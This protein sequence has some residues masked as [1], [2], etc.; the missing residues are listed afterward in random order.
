[1]LK[2][3]RTS[4]VCGVFCAMCYCRSCSKECRAKALC[5][6]RLLRILEPQP[7]AF[8]KYR[9]FFEQKKER[10]SMW[11]WLRYDKGR[12]LRI[13]NYGWHPGALL[14]RRRRPL[15]DLAPSRVVTPRMQEAN[16]LLMKCRALVSNAT[17]AKGRTLRK[18][19]AA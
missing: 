18:W 1:M 9:Q 7:A 5:S 8:E 11:R 10:V 14:S 12:I 6:T 17:N 4:G 13:L 16:A 2:S 15:C 19:N 3:E